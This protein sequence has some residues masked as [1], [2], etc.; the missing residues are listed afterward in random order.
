MGWI[1]SILEIVC[2]YCNIVYG[3]FLRSQTFI[4]F[5]EVQLLVLRS[6]SRRGRLSYLLIHHFP[7]FCCHARNA[8]SRNPA[9]LFTTVSI[10]KC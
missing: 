8:C 5:D 7:D 6:E 9:N 1:K 3:V 10:A 2:Y 4:P